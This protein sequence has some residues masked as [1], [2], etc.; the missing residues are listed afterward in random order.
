MAKPGWEEMFE[1]RQ[2]GE[3]FEALVSSRDAYER[4]VAEKMEAAHQERRAIATARAEKPHQDIIAGLTEGVGEEAPEI[5]DRGEGRRMIGTDLQDSPVVIGGDGRGPFIPPTD[6]LLGSPEASEAMASE[7]LAIIDADTQPAGAPAPAGV[8]ARSGGASYSMSESVKPGPKG[9]RTHYGETPE[10]T[11]LRENE[12]RARGEQ[13]QRVGE[14]RENLQANIDAQLKTK[15]AGDAVYAQK[16]EEN[17]KIELETQVEAKEEWG[18]IMKRVEDHRKM[19]VDD[20][21]F[22]RSTAGGKI[23][24]I[25]SAM[26]GGFL[27]PLQGGK[28]NALSFIERAIERDIRNQEMAIKKVGREIDMDRSMFDD[29]QRMTKDRLERNNLHALRMYQAA[30]RQIDTLKIQASGI[31]EIGALDDLQ[32]QIKVKATERASKLYDIRE[33]RVFRNKVADANQRYQQSM[34]AAA[35]SSA[36]QAKRAADFKVQQAKSANRV[37]LPS[38]DGTNTLVAV[39]DLQPNLSSTAKNDY[40]E[41]TRLRANFAQ[42]MTRLREEASRVDLIN[43]KGT[44]GKKEKEVMSRYTSMMATYIKSISG[45]AVSNQERKFLEQALVA[46]KS[47]KDFMEGSNQGAWDAF[48]EDQA[49]AQRTDNAVYLTPESANQFDV[50]GYFFREPP[51]PPR[52]T[53]SS[54]EASNKAIKSGDPKQLN[55]QADALIKETNRAH[56]HGKPAYKGVHAA[57]PETTVRQLY[58]KYEAAN[59]R[60][61]KIK[62]PSGDRPS[63]ANPRKL[64]VWTEQRE[65]A[66]AARESRARMA[67]KYTGYQDAYDSLNIKREPLTL[68]DSKQDKWMTPQEK[69]RVEAIFEKERVAVQDAVYKDRTK[70]QT[71]VRKKKEMKEFRRAARGGGIGHSKH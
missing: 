14:T 35:W 29:S 28:N 39:G 37:S 12:M 51:A 56:I 45:A 71:S 57:D 58:R 42:Q 31:K 6:G 10:E 9:L 63:K 32:A 21:F 46:P 11:Q 16:L 27:A 67:G 30:S 23:G 55:E 8:P 38:F 22:G 47:W 61:P 50:E 62:P 17:R 41:R 3:E 13:Y 7:A 48:T 52:E 19:K 20:D 25:M 66:I 49:M 69:E 18:Q 54:Y 40:R 70:Q 2:R 64:G 36:R 24:M 43:A 59:K 65:R 26:L 68:F 53:V 15:R 44:R 5:I 4:S 60:A 33:G 34:K 1:A